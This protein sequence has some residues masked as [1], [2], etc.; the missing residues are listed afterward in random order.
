MLARTE[1]DGDELT[2]TARTRRETVGKDVR[3]TGWKRGELSF[4][5]TASI[6]HPEIRRRRS[7]SRALPLPVSTSRSRA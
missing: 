3:W 6:F 4:A 1:T 7:R 5:R 2:R